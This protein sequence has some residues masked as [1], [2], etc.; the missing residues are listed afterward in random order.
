MRTTSHWL[1]AA[2]LGL[3]LVG[4]VGI[5]TT[6]TPEARQALAPTGKL[7]VGL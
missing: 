4:C 3:L 7:R 2:I 6:P 1:M 5:H